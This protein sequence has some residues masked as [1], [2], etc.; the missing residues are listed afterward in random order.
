VDHKAFQLA[1]ALILMIDFFAGLTE[2]KSGRFMFI[3][4]L[5]STVACGPLTAGEAD[6]S[7]LFWRANLVG[8]KRNNGEWIDP[9]G[10]L[11]AK[12]AELGLSQ[13]EMAQIRQTIGDVVWFVRVCKAPRS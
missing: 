1:R 5:V 6:I 2:S 7:S 4:A 8:S 9:R 10:S 13:Q 12:G 3:W 11:T